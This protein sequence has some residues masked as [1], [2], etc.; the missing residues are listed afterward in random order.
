M[1]K[2]ENNSHVASKEIEYKFENRSNTQFKFTSIESDETML[3]RV[4]MICKLLDIDF[5]VS[6]AVEQTD[7]YFDN[8]NALRRVGGSLRHRRYRGGRHL[9]TLKAGQEHL[10]GN[11]LH[12]LEDEFEDPIEFERLISDPRSGFTTVSR[13]PESQCRIHRQI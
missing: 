4:R 2:P 11:G 13:E 5:G 1:K 7:E 3:E 8:N 9:I 12:R 10:V 6:R